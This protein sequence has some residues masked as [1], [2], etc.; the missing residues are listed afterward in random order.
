[1]PSK[2]NTSWV[3]LITQ[4]RLPAQGTTLVWLPLE[5]SLCVVSPAKHFLEYFSAMILVIFFLSLLI[6]QVQ[7]ASINC[8]R[9][10]KVSFQWCWTLVN[11]SWFFSITQPNTTDLSQK[12]PGTVFASLEIA[13]F[14]PSFHVP[15]STFLSSKLLQNSWLSFQHSMAFLDQNSKVLF[16]K[17]QP[18]PQNN[19]VRSVTVALQLWYERVLDFLLLW[20]KLCLK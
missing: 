10:T 2:T 18:F 17:I 16:P 11:Y 6:S 8:S 3:I 14:Q 5:H 9:K 12:R 19:L 15:L 7:L 4:V 1:M 13:Q 20:E